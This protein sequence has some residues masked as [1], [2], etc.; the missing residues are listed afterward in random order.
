[1]KIPCR[2]SIPYRTG[3]PDAQIAH[4]INN[5]V[6][7]SNIQGGWAGEGDVDAAPLFDSLGLHPYQLMQGS[8][9]IG[10][11]TLDTAGFHLPPLDLAGNPRITDGSIDMGAYECL[12][13]G[14]SRPKTEVF[15]LRSSSEIPCREA[16][17]AVSG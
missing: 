17:C 12:Y 15:H 11:G 7:Y 13:T 16:F 14:I 3:N 4:P 8:I 9:C 2:S 1:M 10:A 5:W 6:L